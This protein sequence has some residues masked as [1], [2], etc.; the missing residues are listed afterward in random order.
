MSLDLAG[1][2][3][4]FL[5]TLAVLSYL[6]GD[7]PLYRLAVY[8]FVGVAA[9]YVAVVAVVNVIV[10]QLFLTLLGPQ[11]L[12]RLVITGL[13]WL[14]ALLLFLKLVNPDS[15]L[16]RFPVA[17]LV[18]V[19]AAVAVGGALL[20]TLFPQTAAT[21]VSLLP[22]E[23]AGG[24]VLALVEQPLSALVLLVG[25]LTTLLFFWYGARPAPGGVPERPVLIKPLAWIGQ[26]FIG[27]TFGALYAGVLAAS[28]AY[29]AERLGALM[30]FIDLA[31]QWL[32][33]G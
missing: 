24:D 30:D 3:V 2:L 1:A 15:A 14:L 18:G 32:A 23:N 13:S 4:G 19:G 28:V 6:I 12:G 16:G 11:D 5:L 29:L 10:P 26:A 21:F 8:T 33:P 27:I 31:R 17:Y 9:G 7:N 25:T 22:A 20:G